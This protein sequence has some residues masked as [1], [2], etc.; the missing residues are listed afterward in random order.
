[1]ISCHGTT[2]RHVTNCISEQGSFLSDGQYS[3]PTFSLTWNPRAA[4]LCFSPPTI[5][6]SWPVSLPPS[7]SLAD[8][9]ESN[10]LSRSRELP[11]FFSRLWK[12]FTGFHVPP[13][14]ICPASSFTSSLWEILTSEGA[15]KLLQRTGSHQCPCVGDGEFSVSMK[16]CRLDVEDASTRV[17]RR[18]T[19]KKKKNG[20]RVPQL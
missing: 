12:L 9:I 20:E 8:K 7:S 15:Q 17:D 4:G 5:L 16:T 19:Q 1:M 18:Q 10:P 13:P 2:A 3:I 6:D 11:V 14:C